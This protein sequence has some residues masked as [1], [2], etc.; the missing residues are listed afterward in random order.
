MGTFGIGARN[1]R[2]DRLI[3]HRGTQTDHSKYTVSEAKLILELEVTRW[4]NK[5][6]HRF[7]T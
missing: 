4:G 5:K 3:E 6:L 2:G 1:E 7:D